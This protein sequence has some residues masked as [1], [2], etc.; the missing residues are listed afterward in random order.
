[1]GMYN[2]VVGLPLFVKS[3]AAAEGRTILIGL[4]IVVNARDGGFDKGRILCLYR[5]ES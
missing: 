2:P 4:D 5:T 3:E 1:M